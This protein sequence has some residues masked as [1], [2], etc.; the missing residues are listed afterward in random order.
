MKI[1]INVDCTPAEARSFMGLPDVAPIQEEMLKEMKERT[2]ANIKAMQ[3]T[4]LMQSW[5]PMGVQNWMDLQQQF[6]EKMMAS[7]G[8]QDES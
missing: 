7:S 4:E 1:T 3:P 6:W 5:L 8:E 2:M